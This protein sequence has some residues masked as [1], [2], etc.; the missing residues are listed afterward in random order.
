MPKITITV[1]LNNGEVAGKS[2][3]VNNPEDL[4]YL[5]DITEKSLVELNNKRLVEYD[6]TR[7]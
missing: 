7:S 3:H 6:K 4:K 2:M 1:D 5:F